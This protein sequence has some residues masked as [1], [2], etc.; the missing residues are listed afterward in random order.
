MRRNGRG[1]AAQCSGFETRRPPP[2]SARWRPAPMTWTARRGKW[3]ARGRGRR[4]TST[5]ASALPWQNTRVPSPP[6]AH[7]TPVLS[8]T[9]HTAPRRAA[10]VVRPRGS[11]LA[12]KSSTSP[13]RATKCARR[14]SCTSSDRM[15]SAANGVSTLCTMS[16]RGCYPAASLHPGAAPHWCPYTRLG[17]FHIVRRVACAGNLSTARTRGGMCAAPLPLRT[18]DGRDT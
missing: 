16:A 13:S 3:R 14:P 15:G 18:R 5:T 2:G 7:A 4:R 6:R 17:P 10:A 11:A 9:V 8:R 12:I 1:S